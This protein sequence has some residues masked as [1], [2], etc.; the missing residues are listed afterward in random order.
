MIR[1]ATSTTVRLENGAQALPYL[2]WW[3]NFDRED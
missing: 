1:S 3:R 2:G